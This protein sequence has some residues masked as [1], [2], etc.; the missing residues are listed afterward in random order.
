MKHSALALALCLACASSRVLPLPAEPGAMPV[1]Y[2]KTRLFFHSVEDDG[3]G[4][5]AGAVAPAGHG[6][7]H[8]RDRLR[9]LYGERATLEIEPSPGRGTM[10]RLRIPFRELPRK[11]EPDAA[12]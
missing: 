6:I 8:T 12:R 7:A 10:A 4:I 1:R 9:N 5:D 2:E 11:R 3:V